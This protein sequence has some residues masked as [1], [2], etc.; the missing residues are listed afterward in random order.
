MHY[1]IIAQVLCTMGVHLPEQKFFQQLFSTWFSVRG[2]FNY[3][4]VS[5]YGPQCERTLRRWFARGLGWN[6]FNRLLLAIIIPEGNELIAAQ[7]ASFIPKSGKRTFGLGQ[8]FNGSASRPEKGLEVSVVS[9]VDITTNT[10]YALSAEQTL[11]GESKVCGRKPRSKKGSSAVKKPRNTEPGTTATARVTR[12]DMY[13]K[14]FQNACAALPAKVRHLAVDGYFTN[15]TFVD[16][17]CQLNIDVVGKLRRDANLQ[18]LYRGPQKERGR[19]RLYGGKVQWSNL[20]M[21]RWQDEGSFGKGVQLYTSVLYH[22]SLRRRIRVAVL[23][24]TS[25][26]RQVLLFSTDT[27]LGAKTIAQYYKARFQIEFLFRDA[28]QS[29]GLTHCQARNAPALSFHWNVA[30]CAV[31]IAKWEEDRS[32]HK[33]RFSIN[34]CKQRHSNETLLERFFTTLGLDMNTVKS[35]PGYSDLC[36]FGVIM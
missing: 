13:L 34:S 16:G 9:V 27:E 32:R 7:D 5:R 31:N 23:L 4:N 30:L 26:G 28:K 25:S 20:D 18:Y 19:R 29:T 11:P 35:H 33:Q 22:V 36:D 8:F 12:I 14:H 17:V 1:S 15:R 6:T 2:R 3:T 24:E 10:A 21:R